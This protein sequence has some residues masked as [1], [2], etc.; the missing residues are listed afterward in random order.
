LNYLVTIIISAGGTPENMLRTCLKSIERH[1]NEVSFKILV[2]APTHQSNLPDKVCRDMGVEFM[3]FDA[4][5]DG[6]SGSSVHATVLDE[7]I[8]HI[9]TPYILT[10]DSDCFPM[11][12][13]WID[14]LMKGIDGGASIVGIAHPYAPP[15]GDMSQTGM[16]YRIR[17]QLCFDTPHVACMLMSLSTLK[18]TG[19]GFSAG[20]D[21]GL[22]IVARAKSMEMQIGTMMPTACALPGDEFNREM[23]MIYDN[24]IYHHGGGSR[25]FQDK[26]KFG[27][28]WKSIRERVVNE[29]A[30]FLINTP[31][32]K[33]KFDNEEE[34]ADKMVVRIIRGMQIYL[35]DNDRV[36]GD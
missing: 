35:Q 13:G 28:E 30:D 17:S 4:D 25:E 29:G 12:S 2:V 11:S 22:G 24:C 5:I 20:D 18:K 6:S 7:S 15:Q 9:D 3:S 33:Y 1:K 21:T 14:R 31:V 36:F 32:Y 27:D 23:C 26:G 10:L 19:V 8:R 34:V 16:E